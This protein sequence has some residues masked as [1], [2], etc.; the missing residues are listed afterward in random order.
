[1]ANYFIEVDMAIFRWYSHVPIV[2]HPQRN[3]AF[4]RRFRTTQGAFPAP[5]AVVRMAWNG[6]MLRCQG[7]VDVRD[8][9]NILTLW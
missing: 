7:S 1:M 9:G 3:P 6:W 8:R 4:P 2:G 5:S